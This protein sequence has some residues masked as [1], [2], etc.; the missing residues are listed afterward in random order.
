MNSPIPYGSMNTNKNKFDCSRNGASEKQF[1]RNNEPYYSNQPNEE[2][3][4]QLQ[5]DKNLY[6]NIGGSMT[7]SRANPMN[8]SLNAV[9]SNV[10]PTAISHRQPMKTEKNLIYSNI[11]WNTKP[12]NTYSNIAVHSNGILLIL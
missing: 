3:D 7:G 1:Y 4:T 2:C 5:F 12:E 8:E 6:S 9:Y 10:D 11:Q